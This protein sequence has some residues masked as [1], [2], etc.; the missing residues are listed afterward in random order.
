MMNEGRMWI[1]GCALAVAVLALT[2]L[3]FSAVTAVGI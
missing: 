3:A 1:S 2:V